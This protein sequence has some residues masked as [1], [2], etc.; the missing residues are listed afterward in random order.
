VT[1]R[2][3]MWHVTRAC[4]I[5]SG[6]FI[7]VTWPIHSYVL[8]WH[9]T[10]ICDMTHLYVT[11]L[12]CVTCTRDTQ[13]QIFER[14]GS[15]WVMSHMI[16]FRRIQMSPVTHEWGMSHMNEACH[17]CMRVR[18]EVQW[19][20]LE[21][22]KCEWVKSHI[23]QASHTWISHFTYLCV[24]GVTRSGKCSNAMAVLATPSLIWSQV[25][26]S[27]KSAHSQFNSTAVSCSMQ[28]LQSWLLKK[29][30]S[31]FDYQ[32]YL[33]ALTLTPPSFSTKNLIILSVLVL[34]ISSSH[35]ITFGTA[36]RVWSVIRSISNV[37]RW[38]SSLGHFCHS[39]SKRDQ[40]DWDW[41][42]RLNDTPN[43]T[44]CI[45]H[46]NMTSSHHLIIFIP[47]SHHFYA[48]LYVTHMDMT[49]TYNAYIYTC[50]I[51]IASSHNFWYYPCIH[52]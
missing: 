39:L 38:S 49:Y 2:I 50:D 45:T 31:P 18:C 7:S 1:W 26:L 42:L 17:V 20:I 35:L 11:W 52:T 47:S 24:S 29:T 3:Y 25:D 21:Y 4:V 13:R 10:F 48:C 30:T 40:R 46:M 14:N 37:N 41:R 34:P 27:P 28:Q 15:A 5:R 43:A 8:V 33:L 22:D 6:K 16:E 36:Y 9:D 12:I 19:Q 44:G 51:V 23:I 32:A